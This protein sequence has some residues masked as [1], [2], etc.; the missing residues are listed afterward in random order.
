[1]RDYW[2]R[3]GVLRRAVSVGS[4]LAVLAPPCSLVAALV[5][6]RLL[7]SSAAG[8]GDLVGAVLGIHLGFWAAAVVVFATAARLGSRPFW[9]VVLGA[10]GLLP[11]TLL[12][13]ALATNLGA[14]LPVTIVLL[15][16]F[17]SACST[18]AGSVRPRDAAG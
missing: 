3:A 11:S 15:W 1:M 6:S 7:R 16:V 5:L 8:W 4:V 10:A 9:V 12:L 14:P 2:G 17:V 18:W 13:L